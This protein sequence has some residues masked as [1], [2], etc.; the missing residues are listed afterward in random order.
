MTWPLILPFRT[1]PLP[2]HQ[3]ILC[4]SDFET[5][6]P[7]P[8]FY[9]SDHFSSFWLASCARTRPNSY[10]RPRDKSSYS[11]SFFLKGSGRPPFFS[12]VFS[13]PLEKFFSFLPTSPTH[14]IESPSIPWRRTE[15]HVPLPSTNCHCLFRSPSVPLLQKCSFLG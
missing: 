6:P 12:L 7:I 13:P 10:S 1:L 4:F 9:R 2:P 15:S 3:T 14:S 11:S 5:S 8:Y